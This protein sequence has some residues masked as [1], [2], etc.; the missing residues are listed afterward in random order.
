MSE[1][2]T[3]PARP[4]VNTT[5]LAMTIVLILA[6]AGGAYWVGTKSVQPK[7]VKALWALGMDQPSN[8]QLDSKF[9]DADDNLVADPPKNTSPSGS[10]RRRCT[11]PISRRT[12]IGWRRLGPT[13]SSSSANGAASRSSFAR[14][15]RQTLNWRESAAVNCTSS[16]SIPGLC[17][18]PLTSAALCRYARSAPTASSR[19]TR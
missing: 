11:S 5:R 19:V 18:L 17:R 6:A 16:G 2:N 8:N 12:R 13:C 7:E 9:E 15:I 4:A 1:P 3:A 10:I 14:R